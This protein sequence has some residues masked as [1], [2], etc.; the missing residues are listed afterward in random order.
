MINT[1]FKG[2]FMFREYPINLKT[3]VPVKLCASEQKEA[4]YGNWGKKLSG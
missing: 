4:N 2:S 1:Q 3:H